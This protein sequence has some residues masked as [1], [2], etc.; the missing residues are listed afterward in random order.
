MTFNRDARDKHGH[1][2]QGVVRAQRASHYSPASDEIAMFTL[3]D[4]LAMMRSVFES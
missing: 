1:D 4:A 3:P 2:A